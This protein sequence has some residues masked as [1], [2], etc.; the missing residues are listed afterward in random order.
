MVA[1]NLDTLAGARV[2]AFVKE[3]GVTFRVVLDP[4]SSTVQVYRV[5]VLP[6][7]YL[8][9]RAGNLMTRN[10]GGRNWNDGASRIAVEGLLQ[11][12]APT[13]KK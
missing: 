2:E 4:S 11:E 8:I 3:A 12:P 1:V 7:T 9:T 10:V 13:T 6:T 5:L